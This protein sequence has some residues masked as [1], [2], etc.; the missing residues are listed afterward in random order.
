MNSIS[1]AGD[2]AR[3]TAAKANDHPVVEWGARLGYA[4]NG[5]L[6][7]DHT[8]TQDAVDH[9][10]GDVAPGSQQGAAVVAFLIARE[11]GPE[12]TERREQD[13]GVVD[14]DLGR[15]QGARGP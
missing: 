9:L 2:T 10:T 13:R 15:H 8:R 4:A 3:E 6:L 5:T 1:D 12:C 7:D 14:E 11:L